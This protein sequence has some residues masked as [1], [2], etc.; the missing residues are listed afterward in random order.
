MFA[1]KSGLHPAQVSQIERGEKNLSLSSVS[2][3]AQ[4]LGIKII[5]LFKGVE[6]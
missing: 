3:I 6:D 2:I 1:D 5:D 4:T